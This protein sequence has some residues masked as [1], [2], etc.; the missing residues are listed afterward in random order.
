MLSWL[1][2]KLRGVQIDQDH[3]RN[4]IWANISYEIEYIGLQRFKSRYANLDP[5][6]TIAQPQKVCRL[7]TRPKR[8]A[9]TS[10]RVRVGTNSPPIK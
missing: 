4:A 10:Q 5:Q 7:G 9:P 2:D 6:L 1:F 8:Q 3:H